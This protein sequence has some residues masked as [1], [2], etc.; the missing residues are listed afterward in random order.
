MNYF[1]RRI[2]QWRVPPEIFYLVVRCVSVWEMTGLHPIRAR[3]NKRLK[4][5]LMHKLSIDLAVTAEF[6]NKTISFVTNWF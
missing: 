3:A 5:Y 2:T 6:D 1:V 4:N